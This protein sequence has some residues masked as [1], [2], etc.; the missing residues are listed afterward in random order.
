MT[1]HL[2]VIG[3]QRCGTTLLHDLLDSHP[4]ITMARPARPEPKVF[5]SDELTA[6]GIDWYGQTYFAHA[7]TE[8]VWGEKSTSYLE[9]DK[10]AQRARHMLGDADIVVQLRD[11]VA[12][13]VS[14]WRFST[15]HGIEDR[16][17]GKALEENL[18]GARRWDPE[19]TSVSPFAYLERGRYI[20]YLGPWLTSFPAGL[21]VLFLGEVVRETSSLTQL[22]SRMGLDPAPE[23]TAPS[24]AVNSSEGAAP[25]LEPGLVDRLRAYFDDSDALL[26]DQLGRELPWDRHRDAAPEDGA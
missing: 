20:D 5:L 17:L 14:N 10:A 23:T 22:Y 12:R 1:R 11:P 8:R 6:R 25:R 15:S 3:A 16:P 21:H 19:T 24:H 4:D 18:G 7:T 13:A 9:D 26:R 2:L